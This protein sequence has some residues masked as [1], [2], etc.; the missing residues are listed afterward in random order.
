MPD[1]YNAVTHPLTN[2]TRRLESYRCSLAEQCRAGDVVRRAE[3]R[4]TAELPIRGRAQDLPGPG[5][6][7]PRK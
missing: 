1:T 6:E 4:Q 3:I 5:L 7:C 2:T